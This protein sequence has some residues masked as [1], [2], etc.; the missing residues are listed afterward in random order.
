MTT[1]GVPLK[2]EQH[3]ESCTLGT[4]AISIPVY[5]QTGL[6]NLTRPDDLSAH[7]SSMLMFH[8]KV[9]CAF[10]DSGMRQPHLGCC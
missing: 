7:A 6:G 1:A 10:A 3:A 9:Q 5:S 4:V 8:S 2:H